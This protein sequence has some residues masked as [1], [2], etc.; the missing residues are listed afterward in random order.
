MGLELATYNITFKWIMGACNKA[1]NCLSHPV[2]LP[3]NKPTT[4]N[5]L[6]ATHSGGPAFNTRSRTAQ[7]NSS[8]FTL[9]TDA[10]EPLVTETENTTPKSSSTDRLEALTQ[11]QKTDPFCKCI[12][13]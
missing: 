12:S 3:Q 8:N 6:S 9:Q 2:E 10:T 1:A 13:K 11:M 4:I 5:I 7:Q